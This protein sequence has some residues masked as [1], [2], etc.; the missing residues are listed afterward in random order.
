MLLGACPPEKLPADSSPRRFKSVLHG[1]WR[2]TWIAV[3][4][5]I[6]PE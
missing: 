1:A 3:F 4:K 5:G 6:K 2:G